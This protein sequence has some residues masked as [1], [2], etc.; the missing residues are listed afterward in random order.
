VTSGCTCIDGYKGTVVPRIDPAQPFISTCEPVSCPAFTSG[1]TVANTVVTGCRCNAGYTGNISTSNVPPFYVSTC[2]AVFCPQSNTFG[3]SVPMGCTCNA[4]YM[5]AVTATS[6][7]PDFYQNTCLPA[8]CPA[9][10][11]TGVI[12]FKVVTAKLVS[13]DS[14]HDR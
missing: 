4:G 7:A 6:I 13:R 2:V 12:S 9:A 1:L 5:G 3:S 14:I 8:P 11:S 10:L